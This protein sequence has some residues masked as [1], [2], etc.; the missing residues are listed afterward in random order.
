MSATPG[1]LS[2][3]RVVELGDPAAMFAG[4][5]LRDMGCDVLRIEPPGMERWRIEP[6]RVP[7]NG[8]E[9]SAQWLAYN[10]S[11]RS[12]ALDVA[13]PEGRALLDRLI[14]AADVV[15]ASATP[16]WLEAHRLCPADV[17]AGR[18]KLVAAAITP[19]GLTGPRRDWPGGD[20]ILQAAGGMLFLNGNEDRPPVRISEETLW[21]QAGSQASFAA[22]AAL[23]SAQRDGVGE[24][25]DLSAHE[26][27]EAALVD[28]VPWWQHLGRVKPRRT[29]SGYGD[30]AIP[31]VWPCKDGYVCYRLSV[32]KRLGLRTLR[33]V[34]WMA[35]EGMDD[36]LKDVDWE[37][38]ST[39]T[40]S[41]AVADTYV[42]RIERFFRSKTRAELYAGALKRYMIL[43]PVAELS[44]MRQDQQMQARGFFTPLADGHGNTV[45]FPGPLF[46]VRGAQGLDPRPSVP[47]SVGAHT[48]E[49]LAELAGVD[50]AALARL[51]S[52]GVVS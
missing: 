28:A 47:A 37:A 7:W 43:F 52:L 15:I 4:K 36:G 9:V 18:R 46:R 24:G 22:G 51:K 31:T 49:V 50:A 41:Q 26:A 10:T 39:L 42:R 30:V 3:Y 16:A 45:Q 29:Y 11:K 17:R 12:V 1:L 32:G 23:F 5:L 8:G 6:P 21:A 13:R 34:E 14:D 38:I 33:L 19:F 20:L 40:L 48:A 44:D 35:E 27:I 2:G 25:I